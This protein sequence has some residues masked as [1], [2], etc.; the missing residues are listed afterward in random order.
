MFGCKYVHL[1]SLLQ[2]YIAL[3]HL[4][5]AVIAIVQLDSKKYALLSIFWLLL[6]SIL[7]YFKN[8]HTNYLKYLENT[9][10]TIP[11]FPFLGSINCVYTIYEQCMNL[12]I[13]YK[14]SVNF[15]NTWEVVS[16]YNFYE[17]PFIIFPL[18]LQTVNP[19]KSTSRL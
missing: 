9:L 5:K 14:S 4:R 18:S 16:I 12:L 17:K 6:L 2:S 8:F 13:D 10:N 19:N 3:V 15:R 7:R 11:A 1:V